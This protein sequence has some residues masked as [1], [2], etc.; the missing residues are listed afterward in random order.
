LSLPIAVSATSHSSTEPVCCS[1]PKSFRQVIPLTD[2]RPQLRVIHALSPGVFAS[3]SRQYRRSMNAVARRARELGW[4]DF[5]GEECIPREA[6]LIETLLDNERARLAES[7]LEAL[8]WAR[9]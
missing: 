5:A 4:M 3:A 2:A 7:P 8:A 9:S 6:S 1:E